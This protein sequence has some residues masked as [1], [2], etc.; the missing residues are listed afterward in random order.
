M[1]TCGSGLASA[2]SSCQYP[3]L[4]RAGSEGSLPASPP[5]LPGRRVQLRSRQPRSAPHRLVTAVV[6]EVGAEHAVALAD[7]RVEPRHL[8]TLEVAHPIPSV[9]P[10]HLPP[11]P[12]LHP[13]DVRR[14]RARD[15]HESVAGVQMGD[16]SDLV[17]HR[18]ARAIHECG[19]IRGRRAHGGP[20]TGRAGSL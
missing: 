6:D 3:P 19:W 12:C 18:R 9:L 1:S 7:E 20:R 17:G 5:I 16:V 11:H 13:L 14:P 2:Y 4:I 15:E 8:S 10:G